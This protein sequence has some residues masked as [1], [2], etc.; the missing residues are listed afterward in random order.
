MAASIIAQW[1]SIFCIWSVVHAASA[2]STNNEFTAWTL[3]GH[4]L[5]KPQMSALAPEA[6][7]EGQV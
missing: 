3:S 4:P 2:R 1:R 7:A 6:G 5:R